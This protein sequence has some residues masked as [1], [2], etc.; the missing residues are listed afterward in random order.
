MRCVICGLDKDGSKEHIIPEAMGNEGFI[1]YKVC[2]EC[3]NKLGTNVDNY[4]TD[5]IIVKILRKEL[6]LLGKDEKEIKIFPSTAVDT[7]GVKLLI[8]EDIPYIA[9]KVE[10]QDGVLRVEAENESEALKLAEKRLTREGF[11]KGKIEECL[12][13]YKYEGTNK[14]Q[15]SFRLSADIDKGRYLLSGIKIAYEFTCDVLE[16]SYLD[17]RV[18]KIFQKELYKAVKAKREEL[19]TC[20]DYFTLKKYSSLLQEPSRD[21]KKNIEP[22]LSKLNPPARHVCL[23]HDSCDHKLICEV[24]LLFK[25]MISFTVMM[26]ED[27]ERYKMKNGVKI[28]II[29]EDGQCIKM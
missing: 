22:I 14:I 20:V 9:P 21:M 28:A 27:A 16:D 26:S 10:F 6:G 23:L 7:S 2:K 19:S 12:K 29:L 8:R 1:T 4:L 3:N 15:P 24:Y 17:D 13:N 25:D 11:S 5:Y 18:A